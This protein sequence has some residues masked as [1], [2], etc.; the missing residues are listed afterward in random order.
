MVTTAT[1]PEYD[2]KKNEKTKNE[3]HMVGL[4]G[5]EPGTAEV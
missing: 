4:P 2:L 3:I 1:N 5:F